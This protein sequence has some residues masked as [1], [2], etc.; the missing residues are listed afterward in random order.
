MSVSEN[1]N[2]NLDRNLDSEI[3]DP[4]QISNE[5]EVI[6]QRLAEQ[7]KTKMTQ[8]EEQL[9][10]KFEMLPAEIRVNRNNYII[11]DK[12]DAEND[13]PGPS[14]L[15]NR[16]LRNKHASN[17]PLDKDKNQDDRF[18]LSEMR[19]LRQPY[20]PLGVMKETLAETIIINENR[21]EVDHHTTEPALSNNC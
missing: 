1:V 20:T 13:R 9:N 2:I 15:Q 12:E 11:S 7:N 4:S 21:P 10:N 18:Q 3:T 19:E 5:I 6:S 16:T 17:I 14:N 8:M